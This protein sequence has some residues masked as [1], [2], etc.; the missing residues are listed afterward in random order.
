VIN[1]SVAYVREAAVRLS[2]AIERNSSVVT[3][4]RHWSA[5]VRIRDGNRCVVCKATRKL[6]SHHICRKSFLRMAQLES[7]NGITLCIDCHKEVHEGFNG[8]ADLQEPMDA[9]GGE[10]IEIM[11]GLFG[12]LVDDARER[13][14]L[15]DEFYYL[16]DPV[17]ATFKLFQ[18][19]EPDTEF[20]GC[21]L[22]QAR[23]IWQQT[24]LHTRNAVLAANGFPVSDKPF[25]SGMTLYFDE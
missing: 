7:G 16:S 9:Q 2:R 4:L 13:N 6:S 21:A 14:L 15:C 12:S 1:V 22:E 18:G 25:L 8:R 5:L 17:L 24:P 11:T 19:F 3:C 10:K 20:R 23:L